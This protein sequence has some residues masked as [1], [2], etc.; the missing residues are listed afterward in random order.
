MSFLSRTLSRTATRTATHT[1]LGAPARTPRAHRPLALPLSCSTSRAGG[2]AGS[3]ALHFQAA[4]ASDSEVSRVLREQETDV[5]I[6]GCGVAGCSTALKAAEKGLRVV[7]VTSAT[8][9]LDCNSFWA[10]G[11]I[12]YKASD[13]TPAL[14]SE[15]IMVAG[16]GVNDR[17]AVSKLAMDGPGCVEDVL[18][19]LAPVPFDRHPDGS[20]ALCLEASHNR[21]RIIHWRDHT[22]RA[23]TESLQET[24]AAHPNILL[25]SGV[26]AVDLAV[27]EGV[28]EHEDEPP[29]KGQEQ[30]RLNHDHGR[31]CLGAHLMRVA[32]DATDPVP[33]RAAATVL[34]T[35]G[36]GDLY[37]HTSN[38]ASARGDGFAMA[39][40]A[41]AALQNMEYVQF[42]PTTL[43]LPGERSFLVTEALRGEGARLLNMQGEAF[44]R[45]YHPQGELA[46][47]D[48]VSRMIVS[49]M[50]RTGAE[51]MFLDISHRDAA[52]LRGRFPAIDAHCRARG[53]DMTKQ[54]LPVVPA[55]HYFCGGVVTDL[56]GRTSL[57][58]LF[59]AGE[60]AC[61]GLH[62]ANRLA[63]TS[64]L[65]GLVWG[66]AIA[67]LLAKKRKDGQDALW[68][69][70]V[71]TAPLAPIPHSLGES[72]Q[73]LPVAP[74]AQVEA[75]MAEIRRT[76][77]E[78][79]GVVRRPEGLAYASRHLRRVEAEVQAFYTST[80]LSKDTV[81]LRNAAETARLIARAA[82][83]NTE[84][85]GTHYVETD[86]EEE[87]QEQM[88][89]KAVL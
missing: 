69:K 34:A 32:P 27:A 80:R 73:A 42:H 75:Y 5:L 50:A 70:V 56:E 38:P 53:L 2:W 4:Q 68:R 64:L 18:L 15:D 7:M 55:A 31:R 84:S 67:E 77:W 61:T 20:L 6:L 89:H 59:A 41:G 57:P 86:T 12:I 66:V 37:E 24:V 58:G 83:R 81:S 60:V 28:E 87:E 25:V 48:V 45:R 72:N 13:D 23:I 36:L 79:V 26:T 88:L 62:G 33:V 74:P 3:R 9:P 35:G 22:G 54:A 52:W 71:N 10:Q 11:G 8:D 29:Q 46:P 30:Q 43:H 16:A 85:I 44:A 40:R 49:E 19:R 82:A 63:S 78:D 47:R 51:H 1:I 39:L 65:E 76:L 17:K 21:A 14:L